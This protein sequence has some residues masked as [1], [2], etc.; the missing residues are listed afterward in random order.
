MCLHASF[1]F[2]AAVVIGI[3]LV[4]AVIDTII[5]LHTKLYLSINSLVCYAFI[6]EFPN[7]SQTS[8]NQCKQLTLE[9]PTVNLQTVH[10]V[11][12]T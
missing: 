4:V 10:P 6:Y 11:F 5:L 8:T 2:I 9:N 7:V 1:L 12:I 3:T